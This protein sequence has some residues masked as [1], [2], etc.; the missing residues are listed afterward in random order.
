[1][2]TAIRSVGSSDEPATV[3]EAGDEPAIEVTPSS[4][5][6]RSRRVVEVVYRNL[7]GTAITLGLSLM[8]IVLMA[9]VVGKFVAVVPSDGAFNESIQQAKTV[10]NTGFTI[11]TV[12]LL[13][14]PVVGLI[15]YF[16]QSGLGG[17]I[18]R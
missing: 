14:T 16:Y 1:M 9:L 3:Q 7:I 8:V 17:Y 13:A 10:G 12:T 4:S 11:L 2:S 5:E 18:S 15:A 6:R